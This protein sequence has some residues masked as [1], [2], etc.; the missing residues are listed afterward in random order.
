MIGVGSTGGLGG[1]TLAEGDAVQE[2]SAGSANAQATTFSLRDIS[3]PCDADQTGTVRTIGY[4]ES[5]T[6]SSV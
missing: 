6:G 5:W 4:R 2:A 1:L 3:Y